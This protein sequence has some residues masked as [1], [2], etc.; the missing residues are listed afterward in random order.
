MCVRWLVLSPLLLLLLR[1]SFSHAQ[2]LD[3]WKQS[4]SHFSTIRQASQGCGFSSMIVVPPTSLATAPSIVG[5][6]GSAVGLKQKSNYLAYR[7]VGAISGPINTML[8]IGLLGVSRS[9]RNYCSSEG[10]A[11]TGFHVSIAL[12]G[13]R[14]AQNK[15]REVGHLSL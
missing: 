10:D 2:S 3:H 9:T 15:G 6:V 14:S 4:P 1:P 8:N 13:V 7:I 5:L 12:L 11:L